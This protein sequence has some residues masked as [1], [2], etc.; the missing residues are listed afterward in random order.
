[1]EWYYILLIVICALTI[2]FFLTM[3]ICFRLAFYVNRKKSISNELTFPKEGNYEPY[4]ELIKK[5]VNKHSI[6]FKE[7]WTIKERKNIVIYLM[8]YV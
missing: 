1:M 8:L 3:Y 6:L 7:E 4:K 2:I 5:I